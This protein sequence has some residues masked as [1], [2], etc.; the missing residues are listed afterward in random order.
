MLTQAD[1]DKLS[2]IR[3]AS[4]TV[5]SLYLAVPEDPGQLRELPAHA[6]HLMGNL[7]V[8]VPDQANVLA[9]VAALGQDWLG[10]GVAI[11]ASAE[12][13]L[14]EVV[15]LPDYPP[16]RAVLG[17]RPYIRP[18]LA[19]LQRHPAYRVAVVDRAHTWMFAISGDGITTATGPEGQTMPDA[20]YAGWYGLDEY[21]VHHRVI[22]LA[23]RH[24][25]ESAAL[26]A[27]LARHNEPE[28]L[29]IGGHRD[30]IGQF[31]AALP[32]A[33]RDMY[34][35]SFAADTHLLTPARVQ[36]LAEP[37]VTRWAELRGLRVVERITALPAGKTSIGLA[38]CLAA[39]NAHAVETLVVPDDGLVPGFRCARCEMLCVA[40]C[41]CPDWGTA[42]QPVADLIEEMVSCTLAD[43]GQVYVVT[44]LPGEPLAELRFPV[45]T[46]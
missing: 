29:V 4:P 37:V 34:A 36:A 39:V 33:I 43:G 32:T 42:A 38:G 46:G 17:E 16:E 5:L 3:A 22:E 40:D 35:G 11:F 24:Y 19:V 21:R 2:T 44:G 9:K 26:M 15:R 45:G 6:G 14:L 20:S 41:D 12:L 1:V 18:L 31:L 30:G 10:H 13:R 7:E 8:A 28:P 27:A 25:R 23:R